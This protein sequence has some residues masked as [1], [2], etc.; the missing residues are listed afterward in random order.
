MAG[1]KGRSG[2]KPKPTAILKLQGTFRPDKRR[3]EPDVPVAIPKAPRPLKGEARREW[4]RITRLLA[5]IEC[6]AEVDRAALTA[7]CF[8]WARY[9]RANEELDRLNVLLSKS[10]KGTELPHPLLRV[11][12]RSFMMMLRT[13]E[14]FGFT[15]ASRARLHV[16]PGAKVEDPLEKL[17][18]EQQERR[19]GSA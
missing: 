9:L 7:Y 19:N 3:G 16:S 11:I 15:A 13:C 2:R 14:D 10:T 8:E 6:I 1:R 17:M 4:K 18:R 12:E 5:E